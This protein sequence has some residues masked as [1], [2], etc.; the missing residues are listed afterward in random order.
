M[1]G[2]N[3]NGRSL[4]YL[5]LFI[6]L[7]W[8]APAGL[9]HAQSADLPSSAAAVS[10][11]D[12]VESDQP[13]EAATKRAGGMWPSPKL[14][15]LM[16]ARWADQ[17]GEEY[18]LEPEQRAMVREQVSERWSS[19]LEE[20]RDDI[21]PLVTE[22]LELR[23]ELT[24]PAKDSVQS[25]AQRA[26][27]VYDQFRKQVTGTNGDLRQVLTPKQRIKFEIDAMQFAVGMQFAEGRLN[28]WKSGDFDP[29]DFW[30]PPPSA[31]EDRTKRWEQ[32][33]ARRQEQRRLR[34]QRETEAKALAPPEDQIEVEMDL[35]DKYAADFIERYALDEGQKTT[36]QSLLTEMKERAT[37]HR[38]RRRAEI[39]QLESRIQAGGDA[40]EQEDVKKQLVELYGPID[41]MFAELQ[42]RMQ[43]V[44][45]REQIARDE[46]REK[47]RI[48]DPKAIASDPKE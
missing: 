46:E 27:P 5:S 40:K 32:R 6:V 18:E 29:K 38:D 21:E 1:Y 11:L 9:S 48:E 30:E 4:P 25:W 43:A 24:P 28:Q 3:F 34:E 15:N 8:S 16:L 31:R 22:F 12:A 26:M 17:I 14:M 37:A 23:M 45:T 44:L 20:N 7:A 19:F 39:L 10:S 13:V 41:E 33:R 36:V 47:D 42:R 2:S 35:W